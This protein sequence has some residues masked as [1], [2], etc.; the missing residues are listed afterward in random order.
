MEWAL[1]A[2]LTDEQ[3]RAVLSLAHR[4][5]F[6]KGDIVFHEGDPGDTLHLID[7]GRT[8]VRVTT[9]MGDVA[10]V[11]VLGPGDFF[12]EMAVISPARRNATVV[13]LEPTETLSFHRDAIDDLRARQPSIDRFL[14][15]ALA[16]EVRRVTHQLLEALYVPVEKRVLR[17]LLDLATTYGPSRSTPIVIPL[18]QDDLAQM[19]GTTR[20]SANKVLKGIEEAGVISL[21][22]G[23]IEIL[24]LE[25][26]T[27]RAR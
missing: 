9:P 26:L 15:E 14:I 17:R 3:R 23:R 7:R 21:S 10:T 13:A 22:R 19:A 5:R 27:R 24:D 11:L 12:G 25:T 1:L 20:P 2:S 16:S 8:A 18:T 4:R 6:A